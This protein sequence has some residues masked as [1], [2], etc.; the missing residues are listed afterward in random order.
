[1]TFAAST[2]LAAKLKGHNLQ[3]CSLELNTAGMALASGG[4][5]NYVCIWDVAILQQRNSVHAENVLCS[6]GTLS[7]ST[8]PLFADHLPAPKTSRPQPNHQFCHMS[9]LKFSCLVTF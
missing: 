1:M 7:I 4:H 6:F 5:D 2:L 9:F 3:V 8:R